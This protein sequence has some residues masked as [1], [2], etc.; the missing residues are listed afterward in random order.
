MS[1]R[2][3][4]GSRIAALEAILDLEMPAPTK[5]RG[6]PLLED[7]RLV[8]VSTEVADQCVLALLKVVARTS[9]SHSTKDDEVG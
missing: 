9:K 8:R 7:V 6:K 2:Y 5:M 3:G 1:D 4:T